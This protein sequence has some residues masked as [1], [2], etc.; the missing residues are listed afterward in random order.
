MQPPNSRPAALVLHAL[1][2]IGLAAPLA[3]LAQPVG[4][5]DETRRPQQAP[6]LPSPT[7]PRLIELPVRPTINMP[8]GTA[9]AVSAFRVAGAR[10][11]PA[12]QLQ[13]LLAPFVGRRLDLRGLNEA[14]GVITRFYQS[15]GH[16]LSYAYLPAQRVADGV[17]EIAVLE[18]R[19]EAVQVVTAQE[20]RLRDSVIQAHTDRLASTAADP[21]PVLQSGVERQLLL[22]GEIAGVTARAAFTPGAT[23]GG[24]EMV[25]SVA[26]DEPL[27]IKGEFN[28]HGGTST[29]RYRAGVSL[30]F[31]DLFGW[32]EQ[33]LA[34]GFT[35]NRGHLTTGHLGAS[36]PVGGDGWRLGASTSRVR[37][38]LGGDF[39]NLGAEGTS[40]SV[41]TE[42]SYALR[43]SSDG[44]LTG[45]ASL[46][47][48]RLRDDILA[49]LQLDSHRSVGSFEVGLSGDF[50]DP[51]GG[52]GAGGVS[53]T[54]AQL[55]GRAWT[56]VDSFGNPVAGLDKRSVNRVN[57]QLAREQPLFEGLS[58]YGRLAVQVTDD[59]L[60]S[61]DK[62]GL[63]GVTA[64][65]AYASGEATVDHGG[66]GS[67]ELRWTRSFMGGSVTGSL[68]QDY[69]GGRDRP[70]TPGATYQPYD[71][72]LHGTGIG[73]G[74]VGNGLSVNAS[75]AW[76]GSRA[77]T[78]EP[79]D[80]KPR[81]LLQLQYT[82]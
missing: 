63:G 31:R 42:A 17:I 51:L 22:L 71:P 35:S 69:A 64:V 76:R 59:R 29:G 28:N 75:L 48:K 81:L 33:L 20:V 7:P 14:A 70:V 72:E 12:E 58:L 56:G 27:E 80:P 45:R 68:F 73:L 34:R 3:A 61:S 77:P 74:W 49:V 78:A 43:R 15:N 62:L 57:A 52:Y 60:D 25:V 16:F 24:A 23:T 5:P 79:S 37:Y 54:H 53:L 19:I 82:P 36:V 11:Y 18:G 30:L 21:A 26:E 46:E 10:S 32:G 13:A 44:N 9:V 65:R 66:I 8:E 40:D 2:A 50:R 1:C 47:Y 39:R 4:L 55:R 67:I 41:A 6:A 38:Q